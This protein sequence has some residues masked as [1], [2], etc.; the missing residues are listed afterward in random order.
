MSQ[1]SKIKNLLH[2]DDTPYPLYA[3]TFFFS[4]AHGGL[5]TVAFPFII[6]LIGGNDRDLGL[7][8]G[9]GTMAYMFACITAGRHLDKF[10]PKRALQTAA[11]T[12][13]TVVSA[14]LIVVN[15]HTKGTLSIN[16]IVFVTIAN[17]IISASLVL[18]WP[19]MMGWISTGHEGPALSRRLSIF[20][21]SW[22]LALAVTPIIG[23]YLAEINPLHTVAL[24]IATFLLAF[25]SVTA[26]KAPTKPQKAHEIVDEHVTVDIH[27]ANRAFCWMSRFALVT[28]CIAVGMLRTQTALL[29]T[30]NL[31]FSKFQF[32]I[33]TT[34]LCAASFAIF[35]IAGKTHRWHHK[36]WSFFAAQLIIALA[37]VIILYTKCFWIF[38]FAAA[39]IGIGQGFIYSSHQYYGVSGGKKRSGLMAIHEILICV[40]YGSGA[41]IGGYLSQYIN[42]YTP[43]QFELAV[44]LAALAI[45]SAIYLKTSRQ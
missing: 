29:F 9:I 31:G 13:T 33:M 43:Y 11:V 32:G 24:S 36:L 40:G 18:F 7:C 19:M 6:T 22:S 8:F 37:M 23:G 20:N 44:V 16:P 14:I 26:A 21:A 45:Q 3:G 28:S 35:Y 38:C 4:G 5:F 25:C 1:L 39:L 34:F 12:V 15:M 30:E 10:N 42:R 41:I 2:C 27:P 17:A